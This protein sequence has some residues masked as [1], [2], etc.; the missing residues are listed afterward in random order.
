MNLL[1]VHRN[2]VLIFDAL[3]LGQGPLATIHLPVKLRL[4]LHG[5]FVDHRDLEA[6]K[7]RR[8]RD[9]EPVTPAEK[10]LPWQTRFTQQNGDQNNGAANGNSA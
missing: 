8:E 10:P 4:G 9:G 2:D 1:D 5:N 6:W 3:N 7:R